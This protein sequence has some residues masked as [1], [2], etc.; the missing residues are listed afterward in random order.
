MQLLDEPGGYA[1]SGALGD[2]QSECG[3]PAG[4]A[5]CGSLSKVTTYCQRMALNDSWLRHCM[6]SQRARSHITQ[7]KPAHADA[8]LGVQDTHASRRH[9]QRS[10]ML[11]RNPE[12]PAV[13]DFDRPLCALCIAA[14]VYSLAETCNLSSNQAA[15]TSVCR[16]GI[17]SG[18]SGCSCSRHYFS[19][20]RL[21][22]QPAAVFGRPRSAC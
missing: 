8:P 12:T 4:S 6:S 9:T 16:H 18:G 20:R 14:F 15:R 1:S 21:R 5:P 13:N 7:A 10:R 3:T 17:G 11:A 19:V 2:A 22:A